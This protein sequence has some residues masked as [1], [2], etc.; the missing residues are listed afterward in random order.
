MSSR[1]LS[2][3]LRQRRHMDRYLGELSTLM[4]RAVQPDELGS[5]EQ[6]VEMR[7]AAQGF[8]GQSSAW[9]E[10]KFADRSSEHFAKFLKRLTDAN[11]SSIYV[12]TPHTI[13]CGTFLAP[14]LDVIK[15]DFPFAIND[16]GILSFVTS[17]LQDRLVLDFSRTFAG[18]EVMRVE[19]QG[20]GWARIIY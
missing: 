1:S 13:D 18:Q 20:P 17:D 3:V 2:D 16:D 9:C 5:R 7:V 14:S 6:A 12:W 11:S 8:L 10:I 19:T 15:F 4:A